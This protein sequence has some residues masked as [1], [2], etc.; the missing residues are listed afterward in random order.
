MKFIAEIGIN[1]NGDLKTALNLID[2]AK[3]CGADIV[4]FQKRNPDVCVPEDQKNKQKST[5]WGDM[6]YLEYKHRIEFGKTEYDTIDSYCKDINIDW[7]ASCWDIDSIDFLRQYN[8]KYHKVASAT[9]TNLNL[10]REI[11]KD[12]KYTFMSTGMSNH[13]IIKTALSTLKTAGAKNIELMHSVSSYPTPNEEINLS[14]I[15][16]LREWFLCDVGYSGH[17]SG[18]APT[19]GAV[20]LGATSIERHVTLDRS[21]WGS[22]QAASLGPSGLRKIIRDC[23][24]IEKAIGD[25]HK[26]IMPSE[27]SKVKSLRGNK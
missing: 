2:L 16:T 12:D 24:I 8:I 4:K 9:L 18:L 10:L 1:H 22:D 14:A 17:E 21:M 13:K 6:T 27:K 19:I 25:G 26:K 3:D 7:T 15:S 5:P 20:A 23:R 11:G